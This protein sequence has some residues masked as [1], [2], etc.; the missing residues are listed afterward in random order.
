MKVR[1]L[2]NFADKPLMLTKLIMIWLRTY[3]LWFYFFSFLTGCVLVKKRWQLFNRPLSYFFFFVDFTSDACSLSKAQAPYFN[4][5]PTGRA[6]S[7]KERE[8]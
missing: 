6:G 8:R 3:N 7:P 5:L 1:L 4:S 2:V